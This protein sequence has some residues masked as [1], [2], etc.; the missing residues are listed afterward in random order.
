MSVKHFENRLTFAKDIEK[1]LEAYYLA[2]P[3]DLSLKFITLSVYQILVIQ[4]NS[5]TDIDSCKAELTKRNLQGS[6]TNFLI[7]MKN[8][9][10]WRHLARAK[11]VPNRN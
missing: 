11:I 4:F 6:T 9:S 3:A 2:Y 5:C 7:H 1:K 10:L 8:C